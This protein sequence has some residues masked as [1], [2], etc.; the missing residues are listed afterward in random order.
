MSGTSKGLRFLNLLSR[1][2]VL[3]GS[4][5]RFILFR[6]LVITSL[7][8]LLSLAAAGQGVH[9]QEA[10]NLLPKA[11]GDF[12]PTDTKASTSLLKEIAP[13]DFRVQSSAEGAYL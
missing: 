12:R 2:S 3:R 9:S 13:G 5:L 10:N 1:D 7:L 11:V 4:V 8:S 6:L